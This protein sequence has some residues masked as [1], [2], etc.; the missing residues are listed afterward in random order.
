MA[1]VSSNVSLEPCDGSRSQKS[2]NN[3]RRMLCV[4]YFHCKTIRNAANFEKSRSKVILGR[5]NPG[6]TGIQWISL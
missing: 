4:V 1:L 6:G 3:V 2:Y 5:Q